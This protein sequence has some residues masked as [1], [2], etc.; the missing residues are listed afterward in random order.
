MVLA[1]RR[2]HAPTL[3]RLTPS[4]LGLPS[5]LRSVVFLG[6][7]GI[8]AGA[9]FAPRAWVETRGQSGDFG[10]HQRCAGTY[11]RAAVGDE[12]AVAREQLAQLVRRQVAPAWS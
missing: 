6:P 3:T 4:A 9:Q 1:L 7:R 2:E 10:R 5:G 8:A 12:R 11:A